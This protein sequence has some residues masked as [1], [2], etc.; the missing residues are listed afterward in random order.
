MTLKHPSP[1]SHW[2]THEIAEVVSSYFQMWRL[3]QSGERY[4]KKPYRD[5]LLD[6]LPA[7]SVGSIEYKLQ[8][9][10]AVLDEVGF[11]W[12]RGYK[13]A[14]NYQQLLVDQI[15][16]YLLNHRL[17]PQELKPV[18]SPEA[19]LVE[20]GVPQPMQPKFD[21]GPVEAAVA[22]LDW[23]AAAARSIEVHR[24]AVD[25]AVEREKY[26]LVARGHD[27]LAREVAPVETPRSTAGFD[28][29]SYSADGDERQVNVKGTTSNANAAIFL[30]MSELE[31]LRT[32]P[33]A[34]IQRVYDIQM[35]PK[36]FR[37]QPKDVRETMVVPVVHK[38]LAAR[39]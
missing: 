32:T 37:L 10:S 27:D 19:P 36:M 2:T 31:L 14:R 13:P 18:A 22:T 34:E 33:F 25:L 3:E 6:L 5:I 28:F 4:A 8:N 16:M 15:A 17:I 21:M 11:P 9:V 38:L 23:A 26:T 24:V 1:G 30:E 29:T 39:I 7:R 35:E 20:V 12:I